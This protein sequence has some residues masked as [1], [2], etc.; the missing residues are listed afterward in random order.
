MNKFTAE[1]FRARA[2]CC[3]AIISDETYRRV[4]FYSDFFFGY[5]HLKMNSE[6]LRKEKDRAFSFLNIFPCL[7]YFAVIAL[8]L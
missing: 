7:L 6:N 2:V 4:I 1:Y 8:S 3:Q 5:R